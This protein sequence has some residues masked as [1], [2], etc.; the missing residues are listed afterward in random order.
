MEVIRSRKQQILARMLRKGTLLH[1]WYKCKLVQS[2]KEHMDVP[3]EIEIEVPH[4]PAV[5]HLSNN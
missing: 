3:Q 1:C 5:G 2:L 4:D